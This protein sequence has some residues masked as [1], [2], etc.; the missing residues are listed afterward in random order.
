MVRRALERRPEEEGGRAES[1]QSRAELIRERARNPNNRIALGAARNDTYY[2]RPR[3]GILL[4]RG[5]LPAFEFRLP[6]FQ[7]SAHSL[8]FIFAREAEGE[9]ID[10]RVEARAQVEAGGVLDRLL[11]H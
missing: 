3:R 7:E 6:F 11:G 8:F 4:D 9:E 2:A 5:L 1:R 10:L